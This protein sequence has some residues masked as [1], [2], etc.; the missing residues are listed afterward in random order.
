MYADYNEA[1]AAF[2]N[3]VTIYN[4]YIAEKAEYDKNL[5]AYN[6]WKT[7]FTHLTDYNALVSWMR[8]IGIPRQIF[9]PFRLKCTSGGR[10]P[11]ASLFSV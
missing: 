10:H 4:Q 6:T 3:D 2:N 7:Y 8:G 1:K 5:L 11:A 9:L